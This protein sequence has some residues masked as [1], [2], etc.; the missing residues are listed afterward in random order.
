[1]PAGHTLLGAEQRRALGWALS[2]RGSRPT[3]HGGPGL[4]GGR[5]SP[6]FVLQVPASFWLTI[7]RLRL[8]LRGQ[9]VD[10]LCGGGRLPVP[11]A[12]G[13]LPCS[14]VR[15]AHALPMPRDAL[16]RVLRLRV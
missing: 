2:L 4:S 7:C 6:D 8:L 12:V 5:G 13:T 11:E 10:G 1:M 15:Q 3:A 16:G 14:P 9:R